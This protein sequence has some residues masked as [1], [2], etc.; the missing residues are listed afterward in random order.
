MIDKT[1]P[2]WTKRNV[3]VA[4][5]LGLAT[6]LCMTVTTAPTW[7]PFVEES[8]YDAAWLRAWVPLVQRWR[9]VVLAGAGLVL[10]C[11]LV[12]GFRAALA[13]WEWGRQRYVRALIWLARPV[14]EDVEVRPRSDA[15][16]RA[17]GQAAARLPGLDVEPL[18]ALQFALAALDSSDGAPC[19]LIGSQVFSG[20]G[21][22]YGVVPQLANACNELVTAGFVSRYE[23][24]WGRVGVRVWLR[25][26]IEVADRG[27]E[28]SRMV[29]AELESR[30]A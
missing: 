15:A 4:I 29:R 18:K 7:V 14:R 19:L 24:D 1:G 26:E 21:G 13:R 6:M 22:G 17:L 8:G 23:S 10:A 9:P 30:A 11:V 28:L 25:K 16:R 5:G 12:W 2:N 3:L 20:S 27:G